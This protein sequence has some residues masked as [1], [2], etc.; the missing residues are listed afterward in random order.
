MTQ[1]ERLLSLKA[2]RA[3]LNFLRQK[4]AAL[5][6]DIKAVCPERTASGSKNI[7]VQEG[8]VLKKEELT[9]RADFLER[10]IRSTEEFILSAPP[11]VK[12]CLY[13]KYSEGLTWEETAERLGEN[14]DAAAVRKR[15]ERFLSR[16]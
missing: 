9:S 7:S 10:E 11:K 13:F 6:P 16:G 8:F 12:M 4:I 5:S 1:K 14:V 15:V 2:Q 3:E